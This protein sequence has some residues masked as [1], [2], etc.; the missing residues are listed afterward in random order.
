MSIVVNSTKYIQVL[1][2]MLWV[3][4]LKLCFKFIANS[5]QGDDEVTV[6]T[7]I[8]SKIFNVCI[9]GSVITEEIVSP[10]VREKF[11][12]GKGN[13]L[14]LDK[15]EEKIILLRCQFNLLAV[16]SYCS[17]RNIDFKTVEGHDF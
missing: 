15:I 6:W 7:Q 12:S 11:V 13:V 5:S 3:S 1:N 4:S 16:Y 8:V 9:D 14:V 17:C 2:L 10:D